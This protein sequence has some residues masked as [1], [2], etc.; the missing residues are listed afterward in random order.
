MTP[1]FA[2]IGSAAVTGLVCWLLLWQLN[3]EREAVRHLEETQLLETYGSDLN[4]EFDRALISVRVLSVLSREDEL[5]NEQ[6]QRLASELFNQ[7]D[8]ILSLQLAPDAVVTYMYPDDLS[9]GIRGQK[10]LEHPVTRY[11]AEAAI[12][13]RQIRIDGPRL[14]NQG[15]KGIVVRLPIFQKGQFWGFATAVF[16]INE[17]LNRVRPDELKI[18][19]FDFNIWVRSESG[20]SQ[21]LFDNELQQ[22]TAGVHFLEIDVANQH[23]TLGIRSINESL[24]AHISWTEILVCV[25]ITWLASAL[26]SSTFLLY[27]HRNELSQLVDEKTADLKQREVNLKQAQRVA[28]LGSWHRSPGDGVRWLSEQAMH[29]LESPSSD[30][31]LEEYALRMPAEYRSGFL[32][33]CS[34]ESRSNRSVEYRVYSGNRVIWVREVVEYDPATNMLI[35]TVQDI[36][37]DKENLEVIWRQA[38]ID[39]LTGLPNIN[40]LKTLLSETIAQQTPSGSL[41][42]ILMDI[43]QFKVINDSYGK[44]SGDE[45]LISVAERLSGTF[46]DAELIGR[47]TADLFLVVLKKQPLESDIE[48]IGHIIDKYFETPL[49]IEEVLRYVSFNV[50]MAYWPQ[51]GHTAEE[52]LRCTEIALHAAKA[53]GDQGRICHYSAQ[54]LADSKEQDEVCRDLRVAIRENDIFMMYQ[55]IIDAANGRMTG[56][57]ALVRWQ[58]PVKGFIGPDSFIPLAENNGL[59]FSLGKAIFQQVSAD[60]FLLADQGLSA[61]RININISR[62]QFFDDG[63]SDFLASQLAQGF[64]ENQKITLEVT[65]SYELMDYEALQAV[66]SQVNSKHLQW[67]LDDFGT[68]YSSYSAIG[69]LPIDNIKIDRSFISS[70]EQSDVDQ[71]IV[72]NIIKMAHTLNKTVTAEGIENSEQAQLLKQL[73]CDYFQGYYFSK[74]LMPEALVQFYRQHSASKA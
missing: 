7:L 65:E 68:G 43:Q 4:K 50:G 32:T 39:E 5:S 8:G 30:Q 74:P 2:R 36:T 62:N 73:G 41:L 44:K 12:A 72:S 9:S 58:H 20:T 48:Q 35:G 29:L 16:R 67:S 52:L 15:G 23:W 33:F 42:L 63:F 26:A 55:P 31:N 10:L 34:S 49:H 17:L 37:T 14:L 18:L 22:D 71:A 61:L 11:S 47:F 21:P 1:L 40:Y 19:G 13:S 64:P 69:L 28:K 66:I 70:I 46:P 53:Q 51:D 25:L 45:L 59:I 60:S 24:I 27:R 6:F 54:L 3:A 56:V 57:E 38:N